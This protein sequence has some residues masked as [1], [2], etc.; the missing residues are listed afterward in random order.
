MQSTSTEGRHDIAFN[1][2][3]R[4]SLMASSCLVSHFRTALYAREYARNAVCGFAVVRVGGGVS[5]PSGVSSRFSLFVLSEGKATHSYW[6]PV[7]WIFLRSAFSRHHFE[8]DCF[9]L[10]AAYAGYARS[11]GRARPQSRS[12]C[13]INLWKKYHLIQLKIVFLI[14]TLMCF[15]LLRKS[16]SVVYINNKNYPSLLKKHLNRLLQVTLLR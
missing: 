1:L 7:V 11:T 14:K 15:F 10:A 5:R 16:V 6:R 12:H 2:K 13:H 4:K 8:F 9:Q 3:R